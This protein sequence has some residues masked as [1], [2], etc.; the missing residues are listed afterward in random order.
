[1][2]GTCMLAVFVRLQYWYNRTPVHESAMHF[3]D[4]HSLN[5]TP[6]C[7][8]ACIMGVYHGNSVHPFQKSLHKRT[9]CKHVPMCMQNVSATSCL[10]FACTCQVVEATYV[11]NCTDSTDNQTSRHK[12]CRYQSF[13][14]DKLDRLF[15]THVLLT[16]CYFR[17]V[18]QIPNDKWRSYNAANHCQGVL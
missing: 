16:V 12:I 13:K 15:V 6:L 14:H 17:I 4:N 8:H 1:M 7:Y 3:L 9:Q 10:S 5:D 2:F 11:N 18:L